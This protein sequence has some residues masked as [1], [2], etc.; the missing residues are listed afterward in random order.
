MPVR[1]GAAFLPEALGSIRRQ[2]LLD[3]ELV[4]VDDGSLDGSREILQVAARE[5]ARIRVCTQDRQGLVAALNRAA[6]EARGVYLARMDA[7][8]RSHTTRLE[9]QH[10][11][12]EAHTGV[13]VLGTAVRR[14]GAAAGVWT[15]P[16][17]D[18]MLRAV[19]LF[20]T[21]F[22]H[23]TVMLRRTLWDA[24]AGGGYREEFRAAEDIDLWERLT[25]HTRFANLPQVLLDYRV[26]AAQVTRVASGEMAANGARVRLRFLQRLGL[27]PDEGERARHEAVAWL[28][29]GSAAAL[30]EAGVWLGR[31]QR[32]NAGTPA[33]DP[34]A[35]A[36]VLS[37]RW[38]E[39]CNIHSRL[40]WEAWGI[41]R[42]GAA[43]R[44]PSANW[45]RW[46]RFSA[47]CALRQLNRRRKS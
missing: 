23:P 2:S 18:S 11:Y 13:G 44:T 40:G 14:F 47:L 20:E 26:H 31:I 24:A 36:H 38:L 10:A 7:D 6:A 21:P 35:L 29:S 41:H 9:K 27:S 34:E 33:F 30:A 45:L 42:Q 1:D 16:A 4:A 5:D 12:L 43:D 8:D 15:L 19:S 28:R 3:W 22:A 32:A 25:D 17:E 37:G 46:L 39:L